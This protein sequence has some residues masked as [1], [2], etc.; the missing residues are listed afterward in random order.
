MLVYLATTM[1]VLG[2]LFRTQLILR[3]LVLLGTVFYIA[4]YYFHP[5][6][7]IWD[8]IYG[9]SLIGLANIIGLVILIYSRVPFGMSDWE[10]ELFDAMGGLEPGMF[11]KLVSIGQLGDSRRPIEMTQEGRRPKKLYFVLRGR[12]TV[13][14]GVSSFQITDRVFIGEVAFLTGVTATASTVLE[15]GGTI[16]EWDSDRLRCLC[17]KRPALR[18]AFEALISRDLAAKVATGVQ[19]DNLRVMNE[20]PIQVIRQNA[21][22]A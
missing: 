7:P 1:Q 16:V 20:G 6:E 22:I 10:R 3:L 18:Q 14:K 9:S 12:T 2:F 13:R 19:P 17:K 8:A 21:A 11:R 5:A 15:R 4:F